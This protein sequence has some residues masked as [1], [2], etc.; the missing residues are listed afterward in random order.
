MATNLG[1]YNIETYRTRGLLVKETIEL[2]GSLATI[3]RV[4]DKGKEDAVLSLHLRPEGAIDIYGRCRDGKNSV[5]EAV[6]GRI[7][8]GSQFGENQ[9]VLF[10]QTFKH[11]DMKGYQPVV[12]LAKRLEPYHHSGIRCDALSFD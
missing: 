1:E 10:L 9:S 6:I 12:D 2:E 7:V 5:V 4:L 11:T 3:V 8:E